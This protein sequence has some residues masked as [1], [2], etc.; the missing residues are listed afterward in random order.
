MTKIKVVG[1]ETNGG[2]R[3]LLCRGTFPTI[4]HRV[5]DTK[6]HVEYEVLN[7]VQPSKR[8]TTE[9]G[10]T[11]I[12]LSLAGSQPLPERDSELEAS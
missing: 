5:V 9:R 11:T 10:A 8:N 7:V 1:H 6:T 4:V 2:R 12:G 3:I